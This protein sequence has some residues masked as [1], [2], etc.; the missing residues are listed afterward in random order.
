LHTY[1]QFTTGCA[2]FVMFNYLRFINIAL[3]LIAGLLGYSLYNVWTGWNPGDIVA[4][5]ENATNSITG[6]SVKPV[7]LT[8]L[9]KGAKDHSLAFYQEIIDKDLFRSDRAKPENGTT[10][11]S[12]RRKDAVDADS[13]GYILYGIAMVGD[14]RRAL[15]GYVDIDPQTK[16]RS[17]KVRMFKEGDEIGAAKLSQISETAVELAVNN[18]QL[19]LNV[20]DPKTFNVRKQNRTPVTIK[21]APTRREA[22][23]QTV[24]RETAQKQAPTTQSQEPPAAPPAPPPQAK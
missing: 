8:G 3:I 20:Y 11:E 10:A 23:A 6:K 24:T 7:P 14:T 4:N 22:P 12:E 16:R 19:T 5:E 1:N 15:V 9:I 2:E 13:S 18:E 17:E 21:E